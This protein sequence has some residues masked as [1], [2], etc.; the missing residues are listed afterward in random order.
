V[1]SITKLQH[2]SR[3]SRRCGPTSKYHP[4]QAACNI[5]RCL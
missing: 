5:Y 2:M 3:F 1:K 4:T